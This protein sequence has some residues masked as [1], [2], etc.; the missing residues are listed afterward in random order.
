MKY[1]KRSPM[2]TDPGSPE[3]LSIIEDM[4]DTRGELLLLAR[5]QALSM[6]E[7]GET[8]LYDGFCRHWTPAYYVG[9][10]QLF[11]IHNFKGGLR[12]TE[13]LGGKKEN[14]KLG[15]MILDSA[16]IPQEMRLQVVK[17]AEARG[18][19]QIKVNLN[20]EE[21]VAVLLKLAS[22]KHQSLNPT[23]T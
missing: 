1:G 11:H 7:V 23:I 3:V 6:P 13:F 8:A 16:N 21:D 10:T 2:E 22:L 19:K 14:E 15:P 18:I 12:A 5:S 20:S 9:E 4:D 17:A